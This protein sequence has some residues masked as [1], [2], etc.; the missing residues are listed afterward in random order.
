MARP[1]RH[2][3]SRMEG[4]GTAAAAPPH[5]HQTVAHDDGGVSDT[6]T[7]EA[8]V[9]GGGGRNVAKLHDSTRP[10]PSKR[11]PTRPRSPDPRSRTSSTRSAT[12]SPMPTPAP[13]TR[14]SCTTCRAKDTFVGRPTQGEMYDGATYY[15]YAGDF[16]KLTAT[17]TLGAG[18]DDLAQLYDGVGNDV[19]DAMPNDGMIKYDGSTDHFVAATGFKMLVG[20]AT[21]G[22]INTANLQDSP[23]SRDFFIGKPTYGQLYDGS[24]ADLLGGS[25]YQS[26][27]GFQQTNATATPGQGF[28]DQARL[29]DDVGDDVFDATPEEGTMTYDGN[30][31]TFVH[32]T[33]FRSTIGYA[34]SSGIDV[35]N[36][37]DSPDSK[38][39]FIA[40]SAWA[41]LY[42]SA[43][44]Y[45][46]VVGFEQ[47]IA[48]ASAVTVT[49]VG[50]ATSTA[51]GFPDKAKLYDGAG[52]DVFDAAPNEGTLKFNGNPNHFIRAVGFRSVIGYG[53]GGG[54][55]TA[56]LQDSA[57]KKDTF[58]AYPTWG[59][60]EDGATHHE[61]AIGF[62]QLTATASAGAGFADKAK[63]YDGPDDDVFDAT[64][65]EGTLKF[66]GNPNHFVQ[67][68]GFHS[69]INFAKSG[70]IDTANL[71]DSP[72]SKD[73]STPYPTYGSLYDRATYYLAALG[74]EVNATA[75][76][77]DGDVANLSAPPT[78]STP[79][80]GIRP[81]RPTSRTP[82]CTAPDTP[83]W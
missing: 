25:F 50:D 73:T 36:L 75:T 39:T 1:F 56:N 79:S 6:Q 45:E 28:N 10:T 37:Q 21:G 5:E 12:F 35:A 20:Y 40:N 58:T 62:D 83:T 34:T 41:K 76:P 29:Y 80:K 33:G 27:V 15:K 70:G 77:G 31:S 66:D 78:G 44:F 38:D 71:H 11:G 60:L 55:N 43:T 52:N 42:N 17:A 14:P 23:N 51:A 3:V 22:G 19:F 2:G 49:S 4:P 65:A 18:F 32:A 8:I 48:T 53:T 64:P 63:L 30:P 82:S 72:A 47:T 74:Q 24:P 57:N 46:A 9:H 81:T 69:V 26:A 16:E 13:S 61:A 67:A 59:K 7:V 54:I 68:A